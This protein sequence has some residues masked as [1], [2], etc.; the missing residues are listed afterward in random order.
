[1]TSLTVITLRIG[2]S[3]GKVSKFVMT[4]YDTPSTTARVSAFYDVL[5]R[6]RKL[7]IQSNHYGRP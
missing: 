7:K 6:L 3:A 5:V 2:Q 1:M 4:E